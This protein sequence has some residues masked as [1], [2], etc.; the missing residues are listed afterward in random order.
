MNIDVVSLVRDVVNAP[1][2]TLSI[3]SISFENLFMIR[4]I[5]VVSKND[6]GACMT[7]L[8]ASCPKSGVTIRDK[9]DYVKHRETYV[10]Q[11]LRSGVDN[12]GEHDAHEE[13]GKCL[14]DTE[15]GIDTHLGEKNH[16]SNI[17][18]LTLRRIPGKRLT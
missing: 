1:A 2:R 18:A 13:C 15:S 16:D 10:M 7:R 5:G 3:V 8:M 14:A 11:S 9:P 6:I 17:L 4:P 12:Q